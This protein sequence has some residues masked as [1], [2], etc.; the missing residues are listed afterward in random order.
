MYIIFV[1]LESFLITVMTF[2]GGSK[3]VGAKGFVD[4][5][6]AIKL[7]QWFRVVTGLVQLVWAAG[8]IIGY[9]H[10][11]VAAWAGVGI[12]ITM[13]VAALTHIRVK[14]PFGEALP[15]FVITSIATAMVLVYAYGV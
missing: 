11:I 9:W 13:L 4:M 10:P 2:G 7:P 1:V 6:E 8:L 15:G 3:L 14:Q 5:F 12:G